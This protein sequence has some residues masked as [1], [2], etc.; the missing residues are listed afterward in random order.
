MLS[1][2][3]N[4]TVLAITNNDSRIASVRK[5]LS[6]LPRTN[7][8]ILKHVMGHFHSMLEHKAKT[9]MT[10]ANLAI[11]IAPNILRCRVESVHQIM[12]DAPHVQSVIRC[13]IDDFDALFEV[14]RHFHALFQPPSRV[15]FRPLLRPPN[16]LTS[17]VNLQLTICS[18][19][20]SQPSAGARSMTLLAAKIVLRPRWSANLLL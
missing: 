7:C 12:R 8:D 20:S 3:I 16:A 1:G 2:S 10:S 15:K 5:L 11:I 9:K 17:P 18:V 14:R 6:L 19:R 4:L 13:M